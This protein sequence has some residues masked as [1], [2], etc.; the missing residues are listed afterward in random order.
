VLIAYSKN[1]I[2][3]FE[4]REEKEELKL[5][6]KMQKQVDDL[7]EY[8]FKEGQL[9]YIVVATGIAEGKKIKSLG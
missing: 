9:R 7:F 3:W 8:G 6:N 5:A 2:K 1:L 4:S